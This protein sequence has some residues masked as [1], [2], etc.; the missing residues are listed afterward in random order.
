MALAVCN[1][2]SDMPLSVGIDAIPWTSTVFDTC[3][4]LVETEPRHS[5]EFLGPAGLHGTVPSLGVDG[6]QLNI[7]RDRT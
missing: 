7:T 4:H 2:L 6:I 5:T 1:D 3:I